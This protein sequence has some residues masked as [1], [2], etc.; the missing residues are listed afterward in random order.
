M[1]F[2][3]GNGTKIIL[4]EDVWRGEVAFQFRFPTIFRLSSNHNGLI[5]DFWSELGFNE[6]WNFYFMRNLQDREMV[7]LV[8]LLDCLSNFHLTQGLE[9]I[10]V[11]LPDSST[12]FSSKSAFNK[13]REPLHMNDFFHSS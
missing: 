1:A 9:D 7:E 13:L 8:E 2:K 10:R 4:W 5:A 3:V 6:C 12:V 11:W